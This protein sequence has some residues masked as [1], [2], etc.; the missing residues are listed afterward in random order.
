MSAGEQLLAALV[1]YGLPVLFGC[2]ALSSM[3]FPMPGISMLLVAAGVYAAQGEWKLWQV[4]WGSGLAAVFGDLCAFFVVRRA[5]RARFLIWASKIGMRQPVRRALDYR[6]GP[7]GVSIFVTRWLV[8]LATVVNIQSGASTYPW[9]RFF[10]WCACGQAL[11]VLLCVLPGFYFS[12][13]IQELAGI[14][15]DLGSA[16]FGLLVIVFLIWQIRKGP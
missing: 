14:L 1:L 13:R 2:T 3:G 16:S 6:V 15:G 7:P 12:D 8:P 5:G 11:W 10:L 9:K 4:L